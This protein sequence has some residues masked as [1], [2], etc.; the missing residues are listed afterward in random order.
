MTR[1]ASNTAEEAERAVQARLFVESAPVAPGS[2]LTLALHFEIAPGWNLYWRNS[3]DSGLPITVKF[4]APQGVTIGEARWP[5]PE[6]HILPG[7]LL[8]YAYTRRVTLL[9]PMS[10]DPAAAATSTPVTIKANAK[11]LVC[12]EACV[13]GERALEITLPS[14]IE[15]LS[16]RDAE[17]IAS[18]RATLPRSAADQ[19]SPIVGVAWSGRAL[20]LSCTGADELIFFPYEGDAQP[21]DALQNGHVFRDRLSLSYASAE[22]GAPVLGVLQ[23]KRLGQTTYHLIEAPPVPKEP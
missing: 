2:P 11:W 3:G 12:K 10:I 6:R 14:T 15:P 16:S 5:T 22:T 23:V 13:P 7:D 4:E 1:R 20:Q 9:F 19:T 21:D 17:L 18:A 8:D